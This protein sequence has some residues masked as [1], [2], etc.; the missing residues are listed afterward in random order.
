MSK[1]DELNTDTCN[2]AIYTDEMDIGAIEVSVTISTKYHRLEQTLAL[3]W[4]KYLLLKDEVDMGFFF[5]DSGSEFQ[6]TAPE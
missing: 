2:V 5:N 3:R 4:V 6:R 1:T